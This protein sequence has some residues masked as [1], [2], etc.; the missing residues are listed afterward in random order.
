MVRRE[1]NV[2]LDFGR[3][4]KQ[5][6]CDGIAGGRGGAFLAGVIGSEEKGAAAGDIA[7]VAIGKAADRLNAELPDVVRGSPTH[8]VFELVIRHA[9][10]ERRSA[11]GSQGSESGGAHGGKAG[12]AQARNIESGDRKSTRLNSSH[13]G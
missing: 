4:P 12:G 7:R 8:R 3:K 10:L 2:A 6:R 13:L 11:G 5:Q 1:L 9:E